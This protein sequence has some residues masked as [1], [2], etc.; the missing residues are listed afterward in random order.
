VDAG[1]PVER[2]VKRWQAEKLLEW[3]RS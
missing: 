3:A 2:I 1:V